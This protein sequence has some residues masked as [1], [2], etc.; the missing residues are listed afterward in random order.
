MLS[1]Q[2]LLFFRQQIAVSM[3]F[4]LKLPFSNRNYIKIT[5]KEQEKKLNKTHTPKR[6]ILITVGYVHRNRLLTIELM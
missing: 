6:D 3:H 4:F 2:C 1:M 5:L